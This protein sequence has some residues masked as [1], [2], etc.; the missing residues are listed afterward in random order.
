MG[1]SDDQRRIGA[2]QWTLIA[3][4]VACAVGSLLYRLL[5][6]QHLEQT[7]ALF[8]GIPSV[9]AVVVALQPA[10]QTVTGTIV[11]AITL[12]L[13]IAAPRASSAFCLHHPFFILSALSWA[14]WRI[15]QREIELRG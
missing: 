7:A 11:K 5:T 8:I 12:A 4:T 2:P 10:A 3:I 13:L 6:H 1:E 15:G 14:W 9:L